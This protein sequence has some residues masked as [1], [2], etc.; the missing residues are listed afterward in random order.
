LEREIRKLHENREKVYFR[1]SH[2]AIEPALTTAANCGIIG[3]DAY[4]NL[5]AALRSR[6]I[7]RPHSHARTPVQGKHFD[8]LRQAAYLL[9]LDKPLAFIGTQW[10]QGKQSLWCRGVRHALVSRFSRRFLISRSNGL[11][12][13]IRR[14]LDLPPVFN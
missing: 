5:L 10:A 6:T 14:P 8:K 2:L 13:V 11:R 4:I 3:I 12:A 1:P 7:T 9:C